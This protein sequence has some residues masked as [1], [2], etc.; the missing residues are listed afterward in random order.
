MKLLILGTAS[1]LPGKKRN[2]N[3]YYLRWLN[4][5][6]LFDPGEGTQR[7][8]SYAKVSPAKITRIFLS[9]FHGDHCLGLPGIIHRLN[10]MDIL[11]PIH[12]YYPSS[13][14]TNLHNLL[15]GAQLHRKINLE[16]HPIE[17]DGIIYKTDEYKVEAF[18]LNH[19]VDTFG[20]KI[21]EFSK[22]NFD[23]DKL[24]DLKLKGAILGE[25][26]KKGEIFWE[27]KTIKREDISTK[28]NGDIFSY[29]LDTG[30]CEN[31][32]PLIKDAKLV[33]MESTYLSTESKLAEKFRHLSADIA[34]KYAKENNVQNLILTHF[35]ERYLDLSEF[36]DEV[37]PIFNNVHIAKDLE[38]LNYK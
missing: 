11:N 10:L 13:G 35:S 15:N 32:N 19:S 17:K 34:G 26:E 18:E 2:H 33:L 36:E 21:T 28:R 37:K 31:I 16:L 7:Q 1:Q 23:K 3:G 8:F 22:M 27:N 20:Y 24:K 5:G 6:F 25:L 12:L 30:I 38:L 29:V 9:H 14:E 4:E